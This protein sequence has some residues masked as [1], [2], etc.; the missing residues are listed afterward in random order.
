MPNSHS[1]AGEKQF[2]GRKKEKQAVSGALRKLW[3][4]LNLLLSAL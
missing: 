4:L 3:V 1:A 2:A